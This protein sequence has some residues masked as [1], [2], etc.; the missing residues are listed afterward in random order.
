M[1]L[2]VAKALQFSTDGDIFEIPE[3]AALMTTDKISIKVASDTQ[4]YS[5][6]NIY[7]I[8]Y[9]HSLKFNYSRKAENCLTVHRLSVSEIVIN[10]KSL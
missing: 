9:C 5:F 1:K 10:D 7:L 3:C 8:Y 2:S 4:M 6:C